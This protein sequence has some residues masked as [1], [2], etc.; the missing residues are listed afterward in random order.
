M[1]ASFLHGFAKGADID[2]GQASSVWNGFSSRLS[3]EKRREVERQGEDSGF[4]Q[5]Q[6]Y[7]QANLLRR[8]TEAGIHDA[9]LRRLYPAQLEPQKADSFPVD[10]EAAA[11]RDTGWDA[12]ER[13]EERRTHG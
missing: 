3:E 5:G 6:A 13:D 4:E 2:R 10:W 11:A 1:S 8:G 9:E 12:K 7:A